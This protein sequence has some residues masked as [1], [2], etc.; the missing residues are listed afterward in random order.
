MTNAQ[1]WGW[2]A[3]AMDLFVA[4]QPLNSIACQAGQVVTAI[5][6]EAA[7]GTPPKTSQVVPGLLLLVLSD[8]LHTQVSS[9]PQ[10]STP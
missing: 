1:T 10:T 2:L 3:Q 4:T 7:A 6:Q 5:S 9:T 8:I